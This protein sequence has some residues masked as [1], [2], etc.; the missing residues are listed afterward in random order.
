[1]SKSFE[2]NLSG[3]NLAY[4]HF[5]ES[6]NLYKQ[7]KPVQALNVWQMSRGKFAGNLLVIA[8]D[9]VQINLIEHDCLIKSNGVSPNTWGFGIPVRRCLIQFE[10]KFELEDNFIVIA[11]AQ[12]IFNIFPK[13]SYEFYGIYISL[14]HLQNLCHTL[15]LPQPEQFLGTAKN[16]CQAVMCTPQQM[17]RLRLLLQQLRRRTQAMLTLGVVN[18]KEERRTLLM[19]NQ[20][21]CQLEE[22]FASQL[23]L[24]IA[25]AQD[26]KPKKT[27]LKRA[28]IFK[29]TE[30]YMLNNLKAEITT[31]DICQEI[32]VSKRAL[33]YLF[34][35]CYHTTPKAYLKQLRLNYL[36]ESILKNP[37]LKINELAND[38]GFF[39]RGQLAADYQQIFGELPRETKTK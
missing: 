24:T 35:D 32:G 31:E 7:L 9:A 36:R 2:L 16:G 25:K 20:L 22:D 1:M 15:H 27:I 30:E 10:G 11:P 8:S 4:S 5:Q 29:Q 14:P 12:V 18:N 26:I 34:K 6:S 23:L 19:A 33:E 37:H 39:H 28:N 21:K 13:T 3:L 17:Q 38:L